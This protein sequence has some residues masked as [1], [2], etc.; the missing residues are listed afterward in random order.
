MKRAKVP[1]LRERGVHPDVFRY[2]EP[3]SCEGQFKQLN[4]RKAETMKT[5]L[6]RDPKTVQHQSPARSTRRS[7]VASCQALTARRQVKVRP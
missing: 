7:Y 5:Y 3:Q 2:V 1:A 6:R 4:E